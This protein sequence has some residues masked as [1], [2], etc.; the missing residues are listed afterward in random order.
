MRGGNSLRGYQS[1][2]QLTGINSV[3]ILRGQA[4]AQFLRLPNANV[5]QSDITVPPVPL[6]AIRLRITVSHQ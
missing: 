6:G 5:A 3:N 2:T 1:P 4:L